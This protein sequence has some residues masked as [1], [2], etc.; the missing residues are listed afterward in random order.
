MS[1]TTAE[2][3][4]NAL[5]TVFATHGLPEEYVT[6]NGAQFIAQEFK[7]F[8]RSNRIK[9]ILSTLYHPASNGEAEWAVKIFKQSMKAAKGDPGTQTQKTI[10]FLLSYRTTPHTTTGCTLAELLMNLR[11][12]TRLDLQRPDLRKKVTKPSSMQPEHQGDN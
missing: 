6:D 1:S 9:H 12:P 4:L 5:R 2:G 11:L 8:L 10:S 7:D 3:T